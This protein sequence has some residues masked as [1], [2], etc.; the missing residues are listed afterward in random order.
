MNNQVDNNSKIVGYNPQTGE[1]VYATNDANNQKAI[2]SLQY[3]SFG[4]RLGAI[5]VDVLQIWWVAF[6][7]FFLIVIIKMMLDANGMGNSDFYTKL[8][9]LQVA[10]PILF[11][12]YGQPIYA[13]FGDASSKH[14]TKGK[15]KRNVNVLNKQGNYLTFGQS[16][17]RML[18]KY[19]TLLLPFGLIITII[20]MCCTEK[21]Q[22]LHD[23]ILGQYVIKNN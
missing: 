19:I 1:P 3:A 17:L 11:I 12:I 7:G 21:K 8:Q 9:I 6:V 23:V 13:L 2:P 4:E 20:V 22:A 10:G 18:L 15:I 14:A 5:F 16:F